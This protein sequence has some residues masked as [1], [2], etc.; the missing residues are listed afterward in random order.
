M[1]AVRDYDGYLTD[2][3]FIARYQDKDDVIIR[4]L[5]RRLRDATELGDEAIREARNAANDAEGLAERYKNQRNELAAVL[6]QA[7]TVLESMPD[8]GETVDAR[9]DRA[10]NN[11][12]SLIYT[13][14]H[15]YT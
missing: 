11:M 5:C 12:I 7:R 2:A 1:S 3:E 10:V 15:N 13:A 6:N 4:A 14:I 9:T 8:K